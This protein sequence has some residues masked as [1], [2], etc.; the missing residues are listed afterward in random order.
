MGVNCLE[1]VKKDRIEYIDLIKGFAILLVIM[2]HI[3][4]GDNPIKI[5]IDSFHM[6]LFFILSGLFAKKNISF[7]ELFIKRFK[8]LIIPYICFGSCI[9]LLMFLT[10]GF[11]G[12]LKE[13]ILFFITGVGRD[14]LWFLPALFLTEL[15]FNLTNRIIK[16][17]IRYLIVS[18]LF[19]IGLGGAHFINN[20]ILTTIYRSLVALGFY[21]LGNFTFKYLD[22]INISNILLFTILVLNL[23]LALNNK[24][25]DLWGL[26]FNNRFIYV[27]CS[28]VGSFCI[29]LLFKNAYKRNIN[30]KCL[31]FF[32]VNTLI[33]MSSQ[34]FIINCI[35]KFTQMNS[36]GT[37]H[38]L[39]I[40]LAVIIIQ[41]P[42]IYIIN[43]YAPWM[44]GKF[45]KKENLEISTN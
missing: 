45:V 23:F 7:N 26:S 12:G 42:I 37:L 9:M 29:I 44:L 41:L 27:I 34:Q 21:S 35:N 31:Q 28:I 4:K 39:I 3:Y 5:W 25:I 24:G 20:M 13:Y 1:N 14:A 43:S 8:T 18:M 30:S 15:L 17:E 6:P 33:I 16:K 32:G 22:K 10:E 19:I 11:S 40:F 36:Y 38:G 2:G